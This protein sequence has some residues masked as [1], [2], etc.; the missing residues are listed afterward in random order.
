MQLYH[1]E[2][3]A[4]LSY[5]T[6]LLKQASHTR[7][8]PS[9]TADKERSPLCDSS[10]VRDP[11]PIQENLAHKKLHPLRTLPKD[12]ALGPVAV[13]GEGRFLMSEVPLY[14]RLRK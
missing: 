1:A 8:E 5:V 11:Y 7:Y 10:I 2:A 13:L 4:L 12:F 6:P 9:N 3:D 14:R